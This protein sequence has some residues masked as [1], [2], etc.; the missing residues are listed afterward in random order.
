MNHPNRPVV[1]D[2]RAYLK[3]FRKRNRLTQNALASRLGISVRVV[4]NWEAGINKPAPYLRRA[5]KD[6]E[7]KPND[8]P[9]RL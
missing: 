3:D 4:E 6:L 8:P 7:R 5:L 2:W 1:K 9:H